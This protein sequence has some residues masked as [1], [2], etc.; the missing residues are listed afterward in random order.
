MRAR[1]EKGSTSPTGNHDGND[2]YDC[3]GGRIDN[4]GERRNGREIYMVWYEVRRDEQHREDG[5]KTVK[6]RRGCFFDLKSD[7]CN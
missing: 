4:E 5:Q 3:N 7:Q 1:R 6:R 2:D